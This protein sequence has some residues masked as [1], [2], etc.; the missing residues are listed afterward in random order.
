MEPPPEAV[1]DGSLC[2]NLGPDLLSDQLLAIEQMAKGGKPPPRAKEP[3]EE[4]E[5]FD[6]RGKRTAEPGPKRSK[7]PPVFL[8][9]LKGGKPTRLVKAANVIGRADDCDMILRASD[10]GKHHCRILI[11]T[12]QVVVE[13]LKS[14]NGVKVNGQ[15]VARARLH[16]GDRVEVAGHGF[17]VRLPKAKK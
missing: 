3:E 5:T 11:E 15:R 7:L 14:Q 9:S 6:P 17:Q 2:L 16:D 1:A 13:D 8:V 4:A 10:V 12:G